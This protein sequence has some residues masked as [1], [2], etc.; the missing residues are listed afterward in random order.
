MANTNLQTY[1]LRSIHTSSVNCPLPERT[2]GVVN[3]N[4]ALSSPGYNLFSKGKETYLID[5]DG[6]VVHQWRSHRVVFCAYLLEN[7]NLLR[8]GSDKTEAELFNAGGAAGYVEVV[9]WD[10]RPIWSWSALPARR[11]LTHH[12]LEPLPNGGCLVLCWERRTKE[13][14]LAVG[15]S[16]ELLPDG[17]VW[18]NR[19]IELRPDGNGGA[20]EVWTWK[21]WDHLC[22]D[23]DPKLPNYV[24]C[25]SKA[26]D[27]FDINRCPV[28][29][30]Q[31]CRDRTA[32][33][34]GVASTFAPPGQTG[35]KDWVHI[36]TVSYCKG[37]DA[38][39]LS[40]NIHSELIMVDRRSR[41]IV[42]RWGNPVNY[43]EGTRLDQRLFCQH[44]AHFLEGVGDGDGND[45]EQT[46][47]DRVLLFN[48]GRNPDR[49]W[50]SVDELEIPTNWAIGHVETKAELVWSF[51]PPVGRQGSFYCTHISCAGRLENGNT[52]VTLGPQGIIFEVT[53][54]G[55]EVWRYVC[56]VLDPVRG[57]AE[58]VVRQGEQRPEGMF[59]LFYFRRYP[60]TFKGFEGRE[61]KAGRHLEG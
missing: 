18:D 46:R 56:P 36:N 5:S 20:E 50:S 58:C 24:S 13:E 28:G 37:R 43:G 21:L 16:P 27:R 23:Y 40:F 7:G 52:L 47:H 6:T 59:M 57:V 26:K 38:V 29:G 49:H 4:S 61:L 19:V 54:G 30:K 1:P 10:N 25:P 42:W 3:H 34:K 17:E 35:E 55:Q 53:P 14:A 45:D 32:F 9:D 12:D 31:G 44:A 51:G 22:Q 60:A 33:G 15:R 48:N 41:D 11:F 2:V 39:L 8:D